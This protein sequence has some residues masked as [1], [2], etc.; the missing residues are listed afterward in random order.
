MDFLN[1]GTEGRM[2]GSVMEG[3]RVSV[4]TGRDKSQDGEVDAAV[5][6]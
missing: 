6:E 5:E 2:A 3:L 1:E 4:E